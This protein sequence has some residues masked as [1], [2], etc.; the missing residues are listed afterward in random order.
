MFDTTEPA[1]VDN[2]TGDE[3]CVYCCGHEGW[4]E[5]G[6]KPGLGEQPMGQMAP[7]PNCKLGYTVEFEEEYP[8]N[9]NQKKGKGGRR[10]I[11]VSPWGP[12]GYWR[13]K[14]W[15]SYLPMTCGCAQQKQREDDAEKWAKRP[16]GE[17]EREAR[18]KMLEIK[19]T[20]SP[21]AYDHVMKM[22]E[23]Y[24]A[25]RRGETGVTREIP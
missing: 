4:V 18:K 8:K 23:A 16:V 25:G 2:K 21:E 5:D 24:L 12:N 20:V 14:D 9:P 7:C 1:R 13:G 15:R 22:L 11:R 19:D 6:T 17:Y 3:H 10:G